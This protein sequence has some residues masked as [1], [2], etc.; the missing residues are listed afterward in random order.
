MAEEVLDEEL[1][2]SIEEVDVRI[3]HFRQRV[4]ALLAD[5]QG[6]TRQTGPAKDGSSAG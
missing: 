4:R 2:R 1:L 6:D 5:I 3:Q